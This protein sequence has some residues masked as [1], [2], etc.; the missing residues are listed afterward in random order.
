V[1]GHDQIKMVTSVIDYVFRE[2]AISYLGRND[3]A[4]VQSED[5]RNT[6]MGQKAPEFVEEE[7]VSESV[8][9]GEGPPPDLHDDRHLHP[10]SRG[11]T[12]ATGDDEF[13]DNP[14][15]GARLQ[16]T[17]AL[18]IESRQL[19]R[20][21]VEARLKGYEGDPCGNCGAFTLVRNGTCLKC[22]SCG[23]TSGCS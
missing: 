18:T 10:H 7:V 6:T 4:Q 8:Y 20:K 2:L 15:Q 1:Q 3:L 14:A 17:S 5:L 12:R 11:I 19:R 9:D 16:A 22:V 23:A 21:I 13:A